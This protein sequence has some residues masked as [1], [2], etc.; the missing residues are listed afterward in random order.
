MPDV[1]L[2]EEAIEGLKNGVYPALGVTIGPYQVEPG[3]HIAKADAPYISWNALSPALHWAQPGLRIELPGREL[4]S[5]VPFIAEYTGAGPPP[6]AAPHRYVF[7]LYSQKPGSAVPN[8]NSVGVLSRMRFDIEGFK[9][10]LGL[11][12]IEAVNHFSSS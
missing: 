11:E 6:G 5:S 12:R 4:K 1:S 2:F 7:L 8:Q 9:K 10:K 3:A